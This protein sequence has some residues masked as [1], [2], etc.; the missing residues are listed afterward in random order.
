MVEQGQL[1]TVHFAAHQ[2]WGDAELLSCY[3][4]SSSEKDASAEQLG[5]EDGDGSH[6]HASPSCPSRSRHGQSQRQPQ[7]RSCLPNHLKKH[8]SSVVFHDSSSESVE[9]RPPRAAA[10]RAAAKPATGEDRVEVQAECDLE[11]ESEDGGDYRFT[12]MRGEG[13]PPFAVPL[14]SKG[15]RHHDIGRCSHATTCTQR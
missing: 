5:S 10:H 3:N 11:P 9:G 1:C 14:W 7:G 12:E 8:L 13:V 15:S 6:S 2:I 4:S